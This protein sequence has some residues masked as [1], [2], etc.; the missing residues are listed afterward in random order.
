M[1][2]YA[3]CNNISVISL[4][5]VLVVEETEVPDENHVTCGKSLTDVYVTTLSMIGTNNIKNYS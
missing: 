1:V 2:L 4:W 3:T 5:S